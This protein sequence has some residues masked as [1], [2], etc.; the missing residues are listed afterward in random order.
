MWLDE[1]LVSHPEHFCEQFLYLD[2]F[3]V[4]SGFT[5]KWST[6]VAMSQWMNLSQYYSVLPG[7]GP[8]ALPAKWFDD[9]R[10]NPTVFI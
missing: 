5:V 6:D 9:K 10:I 1:L 2:C 3:L 8:R 7:L 4:C